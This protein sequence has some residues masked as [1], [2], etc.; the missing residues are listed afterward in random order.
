MVVTFS[1]LQIDAKSLNQCDIAKFAKKTF[2]CQGPDIVDSNV[3]IS[4]SNARIYPGL[5]MF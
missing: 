4:Q 3:N 5:Q 1:E 2:D